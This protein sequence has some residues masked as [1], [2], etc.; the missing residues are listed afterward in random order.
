MESDGDLVG[1]ALADAASYSR[2][3]ERHWRTLV[4]LAY[5]KL[6]NL[7]DAE[8]VVQRGF[9]QAY[10]SL[11]DLRDPT[12]FLPWVARIVSRLAGEE[13]SRRNRSNQV[14]LQEELAPELVDRQAQRAIS[15]EAHQ[16]LEAIGELPEPYRITLTLRFQENLTGA[17]IARLLGEP[18]G[19]IRSRITRGLRM[20]KEKLDHDQPHSSGANSSSAASIRASSALDHDSE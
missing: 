19:T 17:E 2:L 3:I 13:I 1:D 12:R 11:K 9:I 16:I 7:V 6:G 5:Q 10:R 8:E 20:L 18:G 14:T 4:G 15:E